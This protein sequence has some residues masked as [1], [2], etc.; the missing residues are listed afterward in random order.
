[1]FPQYATYD[2]CSTLVSSLVPFLLL[3]FVPSTK[4]KC[5]LYEVSKVKVS[6]VDTFK[7]KCHIP[8]TPKVVFIVPGI[9]KVV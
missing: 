1:M 9:P 4:I 3:I 2:W 8:D 6:L 7:V 5:Y